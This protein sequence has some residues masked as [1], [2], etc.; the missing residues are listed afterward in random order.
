MQVVDSENI[1]WDLKCGSLDLST[2]LPPAYL[3]DFRTKLYTVYDW[4]EITLQCCV[5]LALCKASLYS[6]GAR[7]SCYK[8]ESSC[9]KANKEPEQFRGKRR[10]RLIND[11][12]KT[13]LASEYITANSHMDSR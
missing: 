7:G 2:P 10:K 11:G 3:H 8:G 13:L 12:K 1:P 4:N 5:P 6:S 9:D